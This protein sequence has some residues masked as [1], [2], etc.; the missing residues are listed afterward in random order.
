M[1]MHMAMTSPTTFNCHLCKSNFVGS[2]WR[3]KGL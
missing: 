2:T 1:A 3:R